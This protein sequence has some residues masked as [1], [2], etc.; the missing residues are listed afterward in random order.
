MIAQY[1]L[2]LGGTDKNARSKIRLVVV[3]GSV[4]DFTSESG[5]IVNAANQGCLWGGGVDGAITNAGGPQLARDREVLPVLKITR[6]GG[7]VRCPTGHAKL[8]GPSADRTY[9]SLGV[10]YVIHA[11]GPNYMHYDEDF[12]VDT[13]HRLLYSAYR[14]SLDCTLETEGPAIAEIGFSL[15]SAGIFRG[16]QSVHRVLGIGVQAIRDWARE[17]HHDDEGD[18]ADA[19]QPFPNAKRKAESSKLQTIALYAFTNKE[20]KCLLRVCDE[21]LL[22]QVQ[23]DENGSS[24]ANNNNN[25]TTADKKKCVETAAVG[26]NKADVTKSSKKEDPTTEVHPPEST[27]NENNNNLLDAKESSPGIDDAT[28]EKNE[29]E[30]VGEKEDKVMTD[31]EEDNSGSEESPQKLD[32]VRMMKD[33]VGESTAEQRRQIQVPQV[34]AQQQQRIKL[35]R[36]DTIVPQQTLQG[37]VAQ[38]KSKRTADDKIMADAAESLGEG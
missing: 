7:D 21:L 26:R 10:P 33:V 32:S 34:Q 35:V 25:D 14:Q 2:L 1:P 8:T 23:E 27:K 17:V 38:Q 20:A 12:D 30:V 4:A 6:S 36:D 5:A 13:P 31:V 28:M 29:K 16:R 19:F 3:Q 9:G 11:V 24:S 37:P 22:P 15:L 18:D